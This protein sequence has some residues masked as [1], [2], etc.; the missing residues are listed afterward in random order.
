MG[1]D[2]T[3]WTF[4][5]VK[6]Y[7]E[8]FKQQGRVDLDADWNEFVE[9]VYR[10][11]RAETIDIIGRSVVPE[12]TPNAFFITPSGPSMFTIGIGRMYVDGLLA[13]CHGLNP[14]VFDAILGELDGTLPIAF[15]AQPYYPNPNP[16]PTPGPAVDLVYVDVWQREMLAIQD[17]NIREKALGGPDTTTRMQTVWQVKILP[18]VG[19]HACGDDIPAWDTLIAP[20]AGRLTTSTTVPAPSPDPCILS[21]TGGYRGLENRLYRVE[22]HTAGTVG[23]ANPAKF[24]WSRDNGSVVSGVNAISVPGGPNSV[25]TLTSL[26]RDQV[27]R[28]K[29]GDWVEILDDH[30]EF[31]ENDF[32]GTNFIGKPGF[33]TQICMPPDE[34]NRTITV[35]PA[36]P[37]AVFDPTDPTRHTRVR[38][39]DQRFTGAGSDVDPGTGLIT[40][41]AAPLDIED[42]IQVSF[43]GDPAG[44]LLHVGDYWLFAARTADGSVEALQNA[45]PKGILHHYA[46]LGFMTWTAGGTGTFQDC[47][48]LWP[49]TCGD[50]TGCCTVTVGDGVNSHG[51]FINDIQGAIDS[52][53][54][55]GGIVCLGRG[56]FLV[57]KTILINASKK[58]V[59][60]RGMGWATKLI[61][62]PDSQAGFRV[63]FDVEKTSHV[64][65]E[66]FFAV[67]RS[68]QSIVRI[69]GSQFCSVRDTALINLNISGAG[70]NAF[71]TVSDVATAGRA[72]ELFERCFDIQIER[73]TLI[74]AKGIVSVVAGTTAATGSVSGT[75][76]VA[77]TAALVPLPGATLTLTDSTGSGQ[78]ATSDGQGKYAFA[79]VPAGNCTLAA[80]ASGFTSQTKP[81]TVVANTTT[82]VDF[83][84]ASDNVILES[85]SS[86]HAKA[87][88]VVLPAS[89]VNQILIRENRI[90]SHLS[91]IFLVKTEECDILRNQLL[92]LGTEAIQSLRDSE[93][94]R[95][96]IDAFQQK[97]LLVL[98]STSS[99]FGFQGAGIILLTGTR[100]TISENQ[101]TGLI[102]IM[103][104]LL[105]EGRVKDNQ[106][107]AL[108]GLLVLNGL[109]V[110][111]TGNFVAG[112]LAGWI[113]AGLLVDFISDHNVWLGLSGLL[114]MPLAIF[115]RQYGTLFGRALG[116]A[117]FASSGS[118]LFGNAFQ[119]VNDTGANLRGFGLVALAK[120]HHDVY[121]TFLAGVV[122][123][124]GVISGDVTISDNSFEVSSQAG[125]GWLSFPLNGILDKLLHPIH[126]VERNTMNVTGTGVLFRCVDGVFR[127]NTIRC[128]QVGFALTCSSGRVEDNSVDGIAT[129]PSDQGL[130]TLSRLS[131]VEKESSY[132][133]TGNRLT[134]GQGHGILIEGSLSDLVVEENVIRQMAQNGITATSTASLQTARICRNE[135]MN[136]RGQKG[137]APFAGAIILPDVTTDLLV[138]GNQ[139][140]GNVGMG[141]LLNVSDQN[142]SALNL[143]VQD[144]SQDGDGN[145]Q[146]IG[147]TANLIQFTGNQATEGQTQIPAVVLC[148]RLI[149]VNGNTIYS[150]QPPTTGF[151]GLL[152]IA[153]PVGTPT[154]SAIAT[155]NI[156]NG[157]PQ[158]SGFTAGHFVASQ[159]ISL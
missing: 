127:N 150:R 13:E 86:A 159:N 15:N 38:R 66:S 111:V 101:I 110:R 56:V 106:I 12:S 57:P 108:L 6:D 11:W 1:G 97:V 148:G 45:P 4:D 149:V 50:C 16:L 59:I 22:V 51:Q 100:V 90:L 119:S 42:G 35:V 62:I 88:A 52:L 10:R 94:N 118:K 18:G 76:S 154:S 114:F 146:L 157:L 123:E 144:N 124:S 37:A 99:S 46:R 151:A 58:N 137:T 91:S 116:A 48:N 96:T 71:Q 2:Y 32:D 93:L 23:G 126:V 140:F 70:D 121:L 9:M 43:H 153:T 5:P 26:G 141:M 33:L 49:P 98:T 87:A 143:R 47:R 158:N 107:L 74:A 54:A 81:A 20:S 44:G 63:L 82:T 103:S 77:F 30:T 55:A 8:L 27:L 34:A 95:T 112:I 128:P 60:V 40:V 25:V 84:M 145:S 7:S 104:F 39:W 132:R 73:N 135:V 80:A 69:S 14:V 136:C 152:L 122:A 125:I 61:F 109:M 139:L 53:G 155:S 21:P 29:S 113:Q 147:A 142:E 130:I 92:G 78:T 129:Q 89:D 133:I 28:F 3:R 64:S 65:L 131:L 134:N 72:I 117:G 83:S 67:A 102:G 156:L 138:H 115:Q 85:V 19:A 120:I 24:K 17:P 41:S 75:V 68:A 79:S 105:T 31:S 36:I